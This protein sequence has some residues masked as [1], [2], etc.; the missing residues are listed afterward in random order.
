MKKYQIDG[1]QA[2]EI[3]DTLGCGDD[4][5]LLHDANYFNIC[6]KEETEASALDSWV[7]CTKPASEI[8]ISFYSVK[9]T[10][11]KRTKGSLLSMVK[12]R[13]SEYYL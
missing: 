7:E 10:C 4:P 6:G 11:N 3:L 5:I 12:D 1:N 8:K 2:R 13:L 9:D